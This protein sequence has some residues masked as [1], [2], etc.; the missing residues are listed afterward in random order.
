MCQVEFDLQVNER[1]RKLS[2]ELPSDDFKVKKIP[3][4]L[5]RI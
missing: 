4:M 2:G 5:K 1:V 3:I